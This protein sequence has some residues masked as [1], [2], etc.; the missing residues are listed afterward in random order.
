LNGELRRK[1][2]ALIDRGD[3]TIVLNLARVSQ[4]DAAGIGELVDVYK[5]AIAAHRALRIAHTPRRVQRILDRVGLF[6]LLS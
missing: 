5:M 4:V 1:V 2:Q 3:R 6:N